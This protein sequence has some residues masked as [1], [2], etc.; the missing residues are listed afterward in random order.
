MLFGEYND[1]HLVHQSI[2]SG[3]LLLLEL[4]PGVVELGEDEL[5]DVLVVGAHLL[6][7][8]HR[9]ARLPVHLLDVVVS[10]QLQWKGSC[11]RCVATGKTVSEF[12]SIFK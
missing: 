11:V 6:V 9:Q 12:N 1:Y 2:S 5:G 10:D 7:G 8:V 4:C 3:R